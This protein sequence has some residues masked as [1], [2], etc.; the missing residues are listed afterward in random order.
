MPTGKP[1]IA[2]VARA[3]GVSPASVSNAYNRP[4]QLSAPVRERIFAAAAELGYAGP[5]PAARSLRSRRAG[6]IGVLFTAG[7]SYAFTDPYS[8]TALR[9]VC[10]VAEEARVGVLLMPLVADTAAL[11]A[12]QT[13]RSVQAVAGA[14]ID[15][16]IADCI[17][18]SHPA[19]QTLRARGIPL[20]Y[21]AEV[22]GARCVVLDE[23]GAGR[24]IGAHLGERG[25][26]DVAVLVDGDTP[27][28][29][30]RAAGIRAG[31]G[32]AARVTIVDAGANSPG[33]ARRAVAGLDGPTAIAAVSDALA[34]G[35][36]EAGTGVAVTGFD[37]VPAAEAAGLTTI[38]QP[39]AE[40]GRVMARMLLEPGA[41]DQR[42]LLPTELI[43]R[44]STAVALR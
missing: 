29:R 30:A 38:R 16:A 1:T 22:P 10:E 14:M 43:V 39:I 20:V 12:E 31:L 35:V 2:T 28:A 36:V 27:Y 44:A 41:A 6:A 17:D 19:L 21:T 24:R 7:L 33:A 40:K 42:V 8:V 25:H 34:L 26:T 3:A 13:R 23:E 32:P 9:G 15:G 37:D 11:D 4:G 5:D 18:T